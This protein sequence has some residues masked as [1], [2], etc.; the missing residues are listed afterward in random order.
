MYKVI[1]DIAPRTIAG[2][3]GCHKYV[4]GRY[5]TKKETISVMESINN[6][7]K[8]IGIATMEKEKQ[9]RRGHDKETVQTTRNGNIQSIH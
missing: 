1:V 7:E 4:F 3:N 9:R 5:C 6:A 2:T 8:Y